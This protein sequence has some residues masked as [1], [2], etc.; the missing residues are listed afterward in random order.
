MKRKYMGLV[1]RLVFFIL[2]L[3]LLAACGEDEYRAD[4][5]ELRLVSISP[6]NVYAGDIAT[7]LGRNFSLVP[8]ENLVY[9][10][11]TPAEVIEAAKDEIKIIMPVVEPGKH[12]IRVRTASGDLTGLEVNYL[13][14]PDHEYLVQTVVGRK[15][16]PDYVDGMGT[17][18][19]TKLPSGV[20]FAPDGSIWFTDRGWN[21]V[22]RISPT[23]EVTTIGKYDLGGSAL[24]QG[25]FNSKGEYYFID[26]AKGM[27]RK[28]NADGT[29][30]TVADGMKSPMNVAFDKDDNMYVSARDNKAI[31]RF[32]PDGAK[33]VYAALDYPPNYCTFDRNGRLIVGINGYVLLEVAA[34]GSAR[35]ICGDG[36][37][38]SEY[39][40]GEPGNPLTAHIGPTFGVCAAADG[41]L[42]YA[43]Q[44]YHVIRRIVPGADGDYAKGTVETVMGT[45]KGGFAD[46][47]G[48]KAQFNAPYEMIMTEDCRTM[49]VAEAVNYVIRRVSI[50]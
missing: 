32:T 38:H 37:K 45:G 9:I 42:Y 3:P 17:E 43:D 10:G 19:T 8:E 29:A 18:A 46:G 4:V 24:W 34:D 50:K 30:T 16:V 35:V 6:S 27:L 28:V 13:K 36:V 15:G 48:L 26:K 2:L 40:D 11:E 20:A 47:I 5:S 21:A 23:L 22:R 39:Y 33:S 14:T 12:N 1:S 25:G 31:Y 41:S 44:R 49:Y 7:I